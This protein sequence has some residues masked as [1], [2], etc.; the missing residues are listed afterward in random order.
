M[1]FIWIRNYDALRV[2]SMFLLKFAIQ[3][4]NSTTDFVAAL[5]GAHLHVITPRQHGYFARTVRNAVQDLTG[6][7]FEL[8]TSSYSSR[9]WSS[10]IF[11]VNFQNLFKKRIWQLAVCL[12]S[13]KEE[14]KFIKITSNLTHQLM[15]CIENDNYKLRYCLICFCVV[16]VSKLKFYFIVD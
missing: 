2:K 13:S 14:N 7:W 12:D 11:N 10:E 9:Y 5:Y 8:S 1:D 16:T 15:Q 3:S 4:N 6:L